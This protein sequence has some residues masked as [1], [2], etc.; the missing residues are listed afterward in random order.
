[1]GILFTEL[2]EVPDALFQ[3]LNLVKRAFQRNPKGVD[4]AFQAFEKVDLHHSNQK[5][6]AVALRKVSDVL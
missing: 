3:V 2:L 1:M 5:V 4:G 6:L